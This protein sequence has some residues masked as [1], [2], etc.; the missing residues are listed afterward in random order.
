ML[1]TAAVA[2][3]PLR[4]FLRLLLCIPAVFERLLVMVFLRLLFFTTAGHRP[5]RAHGGQG[6]SGSTNL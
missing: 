2:A 5:A 4:K 6:R 3:A 1:P